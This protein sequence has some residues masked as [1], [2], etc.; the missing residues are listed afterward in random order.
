M[1]SVFLQK[2]HPGSGSVCAGAVVLLWKGEPPWH[3]RLENSFNLVL[4]LNKT[5]YSFPLDSTKASIAAWGWG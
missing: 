3:M 2:I 1:T 5:G 4:S